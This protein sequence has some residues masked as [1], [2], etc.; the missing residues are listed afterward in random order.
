MSTEVGAG[1]AAGRGARVS[2]DEQP[3]IKAPNPKLQAPRNIQAPNV[4][5]IDL[6]RRTPLTA[7]ADRSVRLTTAT[8]QVSNLRYSRP[9]VCATAADGSDFVIF[10][11]GR[12][13]TRGGHGGEAVGSC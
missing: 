4:K 12:D 7:V 13:F 3:E 9:P 1:A 11:E 8:M 10:M 6:A 5:R 2:D